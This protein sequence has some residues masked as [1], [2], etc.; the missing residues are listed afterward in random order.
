MPDVLSLY[1]PFVHPPGSEVIFIL[2]S[3]SENKFYKCNQ[4]HALNMLYWQKAC[5]FR[6][7]TVPEID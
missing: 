5:F 1:L 7:T 4:A 6:H 3:F 2:Y